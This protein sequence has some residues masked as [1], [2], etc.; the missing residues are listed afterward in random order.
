[1]D[2]RYVTQLPKAEQLHSAPFP[3]NRED[4]E[5][6]GSL[7]YTARSYLKKVPGMMV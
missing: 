7:G 3:G 4:R 2:S 5:F 6:E 1:M